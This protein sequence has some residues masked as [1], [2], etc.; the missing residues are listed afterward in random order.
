MAT[1]AS[2]L[3]VAAAVMLVS[4]APDPA[5]TRAPSTSTAAQTREATASAAPSPTPTL[6]AMPTDCRAILSGGVL[7]Q[8]KD[9]PLNDPAFGP[10]GTVDGGLVCVWGSPSADTTNLT[11]RITRMSR[12]PALDKLNA[13]AAQGYTCYTPDGGT[14]CEKTWQDTQY[15]VTDGRTLFWRDGIMIDTAFSNLAPSGYTGSVVAHVFG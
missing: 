9:V 12:G 7:A 14:R 10:S 6:V 13:F 1:A 3:I 8:L 11:T 4:C 5:P 2:I 15:P